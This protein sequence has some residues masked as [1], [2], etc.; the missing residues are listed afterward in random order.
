[1]LFSAE[2]VSLTKM[3]D[4]FLLL[5]CEVRAYCLPSTIVAMFQ[6]GWVKFD[7]FHLTTLLLACRLIWTTI[8]LFYKTDLVQMRQ[9]WWVCV[10]VAPQMNCG[11]LNRWGQ[12]GHWNTNETDGAKWTTNN[13][14]EANVK[15]KQLRNWHKTCCCSTAAAERRKQA[16]QPASHQ[17]HSV[18]KQ[19]A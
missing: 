10:C 18:H 14:C 1:M 7:D 5:N 9:W 3:I 12:T 4:W 19:S 13:A 17:Q 8:F 15:I 11:L 2:S 6:Q 16:S